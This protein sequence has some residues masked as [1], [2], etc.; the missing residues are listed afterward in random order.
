MS[1][2]LDLLGRRR[3]ILTSVALLALAGGLA[4]GTMPRQEDPEFLSYWGQIIVPFPGADAR[5]VE[6][7][8]VEPLEEHLAEVNDLYLIESFARAEIAVFELELRPNVKDV[9]EAW[10]DTREVIAEARRDF[11][12]GVLEPT[13]KDDTTDQE[14][15]VVAITGSSDRWALARA[16]ER[17]KDSLLGLPSVS[18]VE[19]VGDPEE[20]VTVELDD[21]AAA[22]LGLAPGY[23]ARQLQARNGILAGGTLKVGDQQ[24][25]LRP[26]TDFRDLDEIAATP[27]LLVSGAAI[28]LSEVATVRYGAKEPTPNRMRFNGETAV[29]LGVVPRKGINVV[30]FGEAVRERLAGIQADI[31]P[32]ELHEAIFQPDRVAWRISDLGRS[33]LL[34]M[35]IVA[36]FLIG[37]MGARLGAVVTV[38]VPLVV[39]SS[40]ALYALLGG[41]L[42]QISI[43]A[44]VIALGMLVDNAIVVAE[45]V[46]DRLDRGEPAAVAAPSAIRALAVPLAGATGTTLAAFV[47]MLAAAGPT[48]EFTRAIPQLVMLTLA[49]SYLYAVFVTPILSQMV[50]RRRETQKPPWLQ[51]ISHRFGALAVGRPLLVL[52]CA[53][54]LVGLSFYA[55]SFVRRGFFPQ[56]DRNQ[57]MVDLKLPEGAHLEAT[58]EITARYERALLA[59]PEVAGVTTLVGR[60]SPHFYY[61]LPRIPL[62]PNFAQL[63]VETRNLDDVETVL[64]WS[65]EFVAQEMPAVEITARR[66][67]QGPPVKAPIEVRLFGEDPEHLEEAVGRVVAEL[68]GIPQAV[69]VRHDLSLGSPTVDFRIDDAAA[70][71]RGISR[72]DVAHALFGRTRGLPAGEYRAGEDPVPIVVRSSAGEDLPVDSLGGLQ[73]ATADGDTVPL[74]QVATVGLEWRPAAIYHRN[75]RRVVSV[76]SQLAFGA[77]YNQ[78]L[79]ELQPALAE[80]TL[81]PGVEWA[82]GGESEGSGDA[83]AALVRMVPLGL[84]LLMGIL[85]AE[86][87]SFR[88][89]AIVMVT[90]PLAAAGV[91]P[92]LLIGG[93][94]FG[95]TSTLGLIALVGIVVNNA[96]VLLDVVEK[97]RRA[98]APIAE[99][100]ASAVERRTR[101]ILLTT[102]TT[103]AGLLPLAFS[104]TSLWPPMAWSMISGLLAST[105]LTLLVVPALYTLLFSRWNDLPFRRAATATTLVL[106]LS[107]VLA[108][109]ALRAEETDD[110][111]RTDPTV[112]ASPIEVTLAEAMDQ[113]FSRP[114]AEAAMEQAIA[115]GWNA[116]AERR[117]GWL[118]LLDVFASAV[119]RSQ[120]LAFDTPIGELTFVERSNETAEVVVSQPLLDLR[121]RRFLAP[122]AR[123]DAESLGFDALRIGHQAVAQAGLVFVDL[124]GVAARLETTATFIDSLENRL[125]EANARFDRGRALE[126]DVLKVRLALDSALQDRVALEAQQEV[127][128]F[129]LGRAIAYQGGVAAAWDGV[130]ELPSPASFEVLFEAGLAHRPDYRTYTERERGATLRREA[131]RAELLPRLN[132]YGRWSWDSGSPFDPKDQVEGGLQ[133][134]WTPFDRATRGPRRVAAE[135]RLASIQAERREAERV[136]EIDIRQALAAIRVADQA[137]ATA[138][139][140][141]DQAGETLRVERRRQEAGRSTTNDLL[142]AEAALRDQRTREELA[143]LDIVRGWVL[144]GL[145]VGDPELVLRGGEL[146]QGA[147]KSPLEIYR[148]RFGDG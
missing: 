138:I 147:P 93:Q 21:A 55:S 32:L 136:V 23:L 140:G 37:A 126:S 95:F 111:P 11:P 139:T 120:A 105:L 146:L 63:A 98:G 79:A 9:D 61:N 106:A 117:E 16:A 41:Q 59:R 18:R 108:A 53:A 42:H 116:E 85:L 148:E 10:D 56:S 109:P 118:P 65:R 103:I 15:V 78:V 121:R 124:Q 81:P 100:L 35:V 14:S 133:I 47:P 143:R 144:L 5:T 125:A 36:C 74:E 44:L 29:G 141:V 128:R 73:I 122:A 33:L 104:S 22:R 24:V 40:L 129:E 119:T 88:R 145:A 80:M 62:A 31:A 43:A 94:P 66:L 71:R 39:F 82:L 142:E 6:R 113:A 52:A 135:S 115:A 83:N 50:L 75:G 1:F 8:V 87:N 67:E 49:M 26:H 48:A 34:S 7:L 54:L 101:P 30:K 70:A 127:L 20:Q 96:I 2:L 92:G 45:N 68:R 130:P 97:R 132:G 77:S 131:V 38:I 137:L 58:N 69:D 46:Q 134:R 51:S 3:M 17:V 72:A 76:T 110:D 91:V 12:A 86:F 112:V 123:T 28:P 57:L 107:A 90:V 13:F 19:I 99:A 114:G 64:T 27:I 89:I 25:T 102:G 4:W 84:L 60:S